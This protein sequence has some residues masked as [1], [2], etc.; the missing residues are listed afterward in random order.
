MAVAAMDVTPSLL[1]RFGEWLEVHLG[2]HFP[3][4]RFRE[5][6][7]GISDAAAE[8][9]FDEAENYWQWLSSPASGHAAAEKLARF[10]TVGETYFFREESTFK[11]L[12]EKVLPEIFAARRREGNRL[13]I[14]SAACCTGEEPYSLAIL[15]ARI[16]P[17]WR[18]WD[19]RIRG[20]DINPDFLEKARRGVYGKWSF[21]GAAAEKV[22]DSVKLL[23]DGNMEVTPEIKGLVAFSRHNLAD[24]AFSPE[25]SGF[26]GQDLIL[27]RNVLIYFAPEAWRTALRN[28]A[29]AL[30][31][32]GRLVVSPTE[33]S[34]LFQSDFEL[35]IAPG[36]PFYR[37][38]SARPSPPASAP[39]E[40]A[41][42]LFF[43]A[44]PP[45]PPVPAATPPVALAGSG[46]E[47]LAQAR[48]QAD[49]GD[50]SAALAWCEKALAADRHDP[51][52]HYLHAVILQEAA[53]DAEAA[54]ALG[55]ALYLDP[56]F[57][58][59][60]FGLGSLALRRDAFPE[61]ARHFRA[62][63]ELLRPLDRD[64]IVPHSDGMRVGKLRDMIGHS[65]AKG[66]AH[67]G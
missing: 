8:A 55:R 22:G 56:G 59:A 10:V 1:R 64:A 20:T 50:I 18:S 66:G 7:R 35:A 34:P 28:F 14:W 52:A 36:L 45:A 44:W 11:A 2:L 21:R 23:P 47:P 6:E 4:S 58:L 24:P 62:A 3:E 19:I 48:A 25:A 54:R 60:H 43:K 5:L 16:L 29:R 38:K 57:V 31:P 63:L 67:G 46:P 15:I 37:K 39:A 53:H 30:A 17:D 40:S 9:G 26:G 41:E 33:T 32:D 42:E 12:E 61:A 27:C 51:A 65:L 13:R 49:Q